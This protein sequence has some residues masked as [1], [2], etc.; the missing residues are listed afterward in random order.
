MKPVLWH[1]PVSHYNEKVR[2][3]LALKGVEHE[4]RAPP[5]PGHMVAAMW[6][7]RGRQYTFPV[8]T[9]DGRHIGDSTSIIAALEERYPEP[10][11]Y[12]ADP[13]ER[14]RALEL[15]D[16]F[17]EELGPHIR[18]LVWHELIK[19]RERM[20]ELTARTAPAPL[21]R[22][23]GLGSAVASAFVAVR[24]RAHDDERAETARRKVREALDRLEAELDGDY[25]VG[26]RFT[27]ADLTA[28]SLFYPLVLP[29]EGPVVVRDPGAGFERFR[30]PLSERPGYRWVAETFARHR[31]PTGSV[32][33][34]P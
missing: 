32:A 29:P 5:P 7:T 34:S 24:F 8:L 30:Q 21:S 16:Y 17:D 15:E 3:A 9:L 27:V 19:D 33:A 6:L 18:L 26:D 2:W 23:P 1:I 31:K 11:L 12:P 14:T 25:L 13:A 4:R 10:A 22:M 20:K 28:A